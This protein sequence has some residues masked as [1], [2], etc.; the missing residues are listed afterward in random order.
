M[1]IP[2]AVFFTW[3]EDELSNG[4]SVT[5]TVKGVSMLP[6]LRSN[7][8]CVRIV[9]C[10][11]DDIKPGDIVLFRNRG[12]HILHRFIKRD[13]DAYL[14]RGDNVFSHCETCSADDILGKV[15]LIKRGS[16]EISPNAHIWKPIIFLWR[17]KGLA[18]LAVSR[19]L[20]K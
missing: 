7:R 10:S 20:R 19:R 12:V 8:D 17:L 9:K 13:G 3:V 11:S 18:Y 1:E 6:M 4:N 2:N 15:V 14:M 5:I 16:K